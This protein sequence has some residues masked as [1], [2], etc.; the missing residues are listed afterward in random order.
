MVFLDPI[1]LLT[2]N[3]DRLLVD[4]SHLGGSQ[5]ELIL[6]T[7]IYLILTIQDLS[8]HISKPFVRG[9]KK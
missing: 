7:P 5:L 2:W 6:L 9:F 4:C 1:D 3:R 8:L